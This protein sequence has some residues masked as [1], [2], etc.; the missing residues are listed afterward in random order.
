MLKHSPMRCLQKDVQCDFAVL[1][2]H[3]DAYYQTQG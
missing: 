1:S 3:T 2:P